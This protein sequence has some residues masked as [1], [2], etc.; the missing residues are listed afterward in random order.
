M[1]SMIKYGEKHADFVQI[2][3]DKKTERSVD[4][5]NNCID[6]LQ[7]KK[8][9]FYSAKVWI[10]GKEGVAYSN[11][12]GL[13]VV[14]KAIKIA[15]MNAKKE[16]F[17]GIPEKQTYPKEN[18]SGEFA[19]KD[20]LIEYAEIM[21]KETVE[22][23]VLLSG[24]SVDTEYT[25]S[26]ILNSNGID[27]FEK[28]TSF[29]CS[30]GLIASHKGK[31]VSWDNYEEKMNPFDPTTFAK[32]LKQKTLF[33]LNAKKMGKIP[34]TIILK[35]AVLSQLVDYSFL[36]NLNGK[37][38]EK[39]KSMFCGKIGEMVA[40]KEI[41]INDNGILKGGMHSSLFDYEG[42]ARQNTTMIK[43][44]KLKSFVYDYNTA[45]NNNRD[46]TGNGDHRD[47][48]FSNI[49]INGKN[50]KIDE[51][52][53]IDSIM[54]AHTGNSLTTEFSVKVEH[55][56]LLNGEPIKGFMISGAVLDVLNNVISIGNAVVQK[57]HVVSGALATD[58]IKVIK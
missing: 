45:K 28:N 2:N 3:L 26:R 21:I 20:Q 53:V 14:K 11:K 27:A 36:S 38:V 58:K 47:V 12:D 18:F 8:T 15:K 29:A 50:R 54:G 57:N 44:G 31:S 9:K 23:N 39:H 35:P 56:H 48:E 46:S 37:N 25:E 30:A 43:D 51:A 16:Y 33:Y 34:K 19:T 4:L 24:G 17:F 1:E 22:D 13:D 5:K 41:S 32:K 7:E 52:L 42:S 55:A 6:M 10:K 49:C 40:S